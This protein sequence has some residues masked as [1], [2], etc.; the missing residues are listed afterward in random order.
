MLAAIL[1]AAAEVHWTSNLTGD[2]FFFAT[3]SE[4]DNAEAT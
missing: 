4:Q 3:A 1:C 2:S